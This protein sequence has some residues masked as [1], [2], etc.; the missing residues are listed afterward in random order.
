MITLWL[1]IMRILLVRRGQDVQIDN[2]K[3]PF[4]SV[5]KEQIKIAS[6]RSPSKAR[7]VQL[8][9][10]ATVTRNQEGYHRTLH[11]TTTVPFS[12]S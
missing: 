2:L 9:T 5:A 12:P 4:N 7:V 3:H 6:R 1:L 11:V 8:L 10:R